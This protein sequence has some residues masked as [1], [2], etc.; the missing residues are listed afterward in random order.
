MNRVHNSLSTGQNP[1][2]ALFDKLHSSMTGLGIQFE[3]KNLELMVMG[4]SEV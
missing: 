3:L 1:F 2:Q 4:Y